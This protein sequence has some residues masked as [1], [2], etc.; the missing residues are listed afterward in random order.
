MANSRLGAPFSPAR[1]LGFTAVAVLA[2]T[3][4]QAEA[5]MLRATLYAGAVMVVSVWFSPAHAQCSFPFSG[6]VY[7]EYLADDGGMYHVR[8]IGNDVWW[9]G[10]SPDGGKTW[11]NVFHG[12]INGSR[13]TGGWLDVPTENRQNPTNAGKVTL[14]IMKLGSPDLLKKVDSPSGPGAS[15]WKRILPC[16]D[17]VARPG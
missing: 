2:R 8:Q 11:T 1:C 12:Q 17:N 15:T 7:G 6:Q 3:T 9:P 13:L 5:M 10:M 16:H 14:E 4:E